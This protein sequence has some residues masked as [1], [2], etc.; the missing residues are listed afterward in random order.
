MRYS[1]HDFTLK[2]QMKPE[3]EQHFNQKNVKKQTNKHQSR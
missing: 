2:T 3:Q 1:E